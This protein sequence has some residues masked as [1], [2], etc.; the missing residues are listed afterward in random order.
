MNNIIKIDQ[1]EAQNIF[2]GRAITA[3]QVIEGLGS[4]LGY[5]L[6]RA[7]MGLKALKGFIQDLVS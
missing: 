1:I 6:G 7:W 2:G 4:N 5:V 3:E